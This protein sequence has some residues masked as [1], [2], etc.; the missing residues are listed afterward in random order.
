VFRFSFSPFISVNLPT[1]SLILSSENEPSSPLKSF[2]SIV[3]TRNSLLN[4]GE[5]VQLVTEN[6]KDGDPLDD[7]FAAL[8]AESG[9]S[10]DVYDK[11][12]PA[13]NKLV[14]LK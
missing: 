14:C 8:A 11:M 12:A 13:F 7:S 2:I 9:I 6:L 10:Q 5:G 3:F 4:R 1:N